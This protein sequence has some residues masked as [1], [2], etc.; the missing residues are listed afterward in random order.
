MTSNGRYNTTLPGYGNLPSFLRDMDY[1]N[2]C[3]PIHTNWL[4][5]RGLSRFD[6]LKSKANDMASFQNVMEIFAANKAPWTDIYPV[7][8]VLEA[9]RPDRPLVV[10][11]GGGKGHDI[12]KFRS[13]LP[14]DIEPAKL[15]LQDMEPVIGAVD[16]R[17]TG[18]TGMV[19]DIFRTQP[20]KGR[21]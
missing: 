9:F 4:A 7:Q 15:V 12:L 19:H 16:T 21:S 14:P 8:K 6:D 1:S 2:P 17:T 13:H 20:V 5:M 18:I 10:D 3:D 11:V